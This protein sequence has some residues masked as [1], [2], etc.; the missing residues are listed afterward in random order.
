MTANVNRD[1]K[2]CRAFTPA[3]FVP[4]DLR[5]EFLVPSGIRLTRTSLHALRPI[6]AKDA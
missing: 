3:D 2:K 1:P 6:F 5:K 4:P